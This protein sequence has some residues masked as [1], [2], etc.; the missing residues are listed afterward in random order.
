MKR[1]R[2][3]R[4]LR[5]PC[6]LY[7]FAAVIAAFAVL[8]E[9]S[10]AEEFRLAEDDVVV[11]LGGTNM[12]RMQQA[13]YL[14][15]QIARSF[16]NVRAKYRDLAWEGDTVFRQ[17]TV[18]DRWRKQAHFGDLKGLGSL[19]DQLDR[20]NANVVIVQFGQTE[21]LADSAG[22]DPF[23]NAYND[24]LDAITADGRR[25]ALISPI[26]FEA[27]ADPLIPDLSRRNEDLAHYVAA[28]EKIAEQRKLIFVDLFKHSQGRLTNN[29]MHVRDDAQPR[30]A[31]E[32]AK[33]LE[34]TAV[35]DEALE[36]LRRAIVEKHRLWYDYWRPANW[37]LLYGDDARRQF[38]RGQVS[39]REEW[40]QLVPLIESADKRIWRIAAGKND[41]G[42]ERPRPETLHGDESADI[43]AELAAFTVADGMQVN[44]F[45]SEEHGLTSPLAIRWDP[46]GRMYVTVTTTYPHVRPGDL[47]N[48]KIIVLEDGNADGRADHS[49]V[50]AEGLNIP[51]GLEWGDGGVYVG[52]NT[53]LLFLKDTSGDGKADTRRVVLSGFGN[54]DS[55][56]T[57]N[58]F[59]WSPGGELYFGQGDGCESRVETPWGVS[60][61]YQAGFFRLRPRRLQLH[62]LLDDFMGPGN[63]WGVAFDRWGQIFSIDGAGGVTFLSPGQVPVS[64]RRRLRTIGQPGGYCGIGYLEGR[65][66]PAEMQGDFAV[67]DFKANRVKRFTV[68]SEGAGYKL[69]WKQPLLHSR[70]RNFRPVDVKM[71]PDGAIYIV[72]WYN[73]ITCHQDDAFRDPRRDKAHGRIWRV[74]SKGSEDRVDVR[75]GD[76]SKAPIEDV[77]NALASP[78]Q[79]TRYQS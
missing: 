25:I 49:T 47:P 3:L 58:S 54:G 68:E 38:T 70:H 7:R 13:G 17:G 56:Q 43:E 4:S 78:E 63:P 46:A 20:L 42:P 66:L 51:T 19:A 21:S 30:L 75:P 27:P 45:A 73:P 2:T 79:F 52:Q 22:V 53:E 14:E 10:P 35:E 1:F 69:Y 62:P 74:S 28:I 57:I 33:Q 60:S 6:S 9:T 24:L 26:A 31:R 36:P 65:S 16:P 15:A 76:L 64:H 29:G 5:S 37:K 40:Q 8:A 77:I 39:F 32:I 67:G 12:L 55:H 41:P 34:I 59:V 50:F 71:G 11:F 23:V 18:I 61:L 44:L 48:D 72:D